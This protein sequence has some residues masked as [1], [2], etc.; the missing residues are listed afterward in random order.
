MFL[1]WFSDLK[2][3][4]EPAANNRANFKSTTLAGI[5]TC[6]EIEDA[7]GAPVPYF[8]AAFFAG[9]AFA[10]FCVSADAAAVFASLLAFGSRMTLAAA[11]AALGLVISLLLL[12]VS[13]EAAATFASLLAFGSF[14]TFA[15][16]DAAFLPVLSLFLTAMVLFSLMRRPDAR[17]CSYMRYA[18]SRS[19]DIIHN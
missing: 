6:A 13:A 19:A 10:A 3:A 14:R 16:A 18:D 5:R 12:C 1:V 9:T 4:A 7:K 15:A 11:L 2:F 17:R 8:F